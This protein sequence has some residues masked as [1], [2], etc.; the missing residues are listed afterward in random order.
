[1]CHG[2]TRAF[3]DP[4]ASHWTLCDVPQLPDSCRLGLIPP[5]QLQERLRGVTALQLGLQAHDGELH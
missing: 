5:G 2:L 4:G 1:M 3:L